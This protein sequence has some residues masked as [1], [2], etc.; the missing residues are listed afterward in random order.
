M[1]CSLSFI[2]LFVSNLREAEE[3]YKTIFDMQ[4]I[5]REA[6][7][8]DGL[9]YTLPFDKEWEDADAAGIEIGML[10]L[11]KHDFVLAL[12]SGD[13]RAG[14][15]YAVGLSMPEDEIARV[16]S[17]LPEGIS[18]DTDLPGRLEFTDCYQISWQISDGD[19]F[20]TA[21]DFANRWLVM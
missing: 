20:R 14:Q 2:A 11:R 15:V 10:A 21:G 19:E 9:W 4:L 6:Q 18:A 8:S 5:G 17:R 1:H 13:R 3:F 16:S 7:A 12:F